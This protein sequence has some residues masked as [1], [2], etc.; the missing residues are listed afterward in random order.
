MFEQFRANE[1]LREISIKENPF[2]VKT[3]REKAVEEKD[4]PVFRTMFEKR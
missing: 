1:N 3:E 4:L 2:P